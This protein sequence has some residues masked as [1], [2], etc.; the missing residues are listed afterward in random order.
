MAACHPCSDRELLANDLVVDGDHLRHATPH[1]GP[2]L[3][4]VASARDEEV[5]LRPNVPVPAEGADAIDQVDHGMAL[6]DPRLFLEGAAKNHHLADGRVVEGRD[7][8]VGNL[9]VEHP[10]L[11]ELLEGHP[12]PLGSYNAKHLQAARRHE[13][14]NVEGLRAE[15]Q[16]CGLGVLRGDCSFLV[17]SAQQRALVSDC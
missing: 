9:V 1:A 8:L 7:S 17:P 16:Q 4:L 15:G 3:T 14:P 5:V 2:N 11:V 6:L 13:A 10:I 12:R